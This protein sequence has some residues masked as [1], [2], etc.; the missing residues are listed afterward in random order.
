[1]EYE[2]ERY[3]N[4]MDTQFSSITLLPTHI[5]VSDDDGEVTVMPNNEDVTVNLPLVVA[6]RRNDGEDHRV[7]VVLYRESSLG[8]PAI[9]MFYI[10]TNKTSHVL[11]D[12]VGKISVSPN[13]GRDEVLADWWIRKFQSYDTNFGYGVVNTFNDFSFC[14][15]NQEETTNLLGSIIVNDWSVECETFSY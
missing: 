11:I 3:I 9:E 12:T 14:T 13:F 5:F 1:M 10:N 15:L 2:V 4:L 7:R 8:F 6:Y